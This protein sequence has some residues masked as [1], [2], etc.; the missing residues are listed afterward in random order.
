[1][2][3]FIYDVSIAFT[4]ALHHATQF[5]FGK[6]LNAV[7]LALTFK[8]ENK[9][10]HSPISVPFLVLLLLCS[11]TTSEMYLTMLTEGQVQYLS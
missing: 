6:P 9:N 8:K 7:A 3:L 5:H 10:C 11:H 1:M 4:N 2:P